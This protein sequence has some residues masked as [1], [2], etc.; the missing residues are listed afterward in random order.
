MKKNTHSST[1]TTRTKSTNYNRSRKWKD[2][3][4]KDLRTPKYKMRVVPNKK[5]NLPP[6]EEL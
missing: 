4:A 5:K 2:P 6:I 3:V 1:S